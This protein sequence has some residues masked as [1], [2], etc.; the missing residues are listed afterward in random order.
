MPIT[1]MD[2]QQLKHYCIV[3][4]YVWIRASDIMLSYNVWAQRT[5]ATLLWM[6]YKI[7][8]VQDELQ[9][10]SEIRF[11][12]LQHLQ[13]EDGQSLTESLRQNLVTLFNS[14]LIEH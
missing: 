6:L 3:C 1:L 10:C 4:V 2:G 7:P 5:C 13:A 11:E 8:I 9:N 14:I 12:Q